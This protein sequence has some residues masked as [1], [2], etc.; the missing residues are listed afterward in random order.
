MS[1]GKGNAVVVP[2]RGR[3]RFCWGA[4]AV[5]Q[6]V[7][8]VSAP[9]QGASHSHGAVRACGEGACPRW[10]AKRPS[11]LQSRCFRQATVSGFTSAAHSN[12]AVRR[13]DKPPRHRESCLT[14]EWSSRY[15]NTRLI[16]NDTSANVRHTF[17]GSRSSNGLGRTLK[18]RRSPCSSSSNHS[19]AV[20]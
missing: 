11:N 13:S 1:V 20:S 17:N 4:G 12:G 14:Q 18:L 10:V 3:A 8:Y 16:N 9:I 6:Y 2:N 7:S 15:S 19:S 5:S